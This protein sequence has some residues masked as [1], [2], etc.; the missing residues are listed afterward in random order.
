M[1]TNPI[2]ASGS[3]NVPAEKCCERKVEAPVATEQD[4]TEMEFPNEK[5]ETY[6]EKASASVNEY[7]VT[8]TP[9]VP[10]K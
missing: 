6:A 10:K 3:R 5:G 8:W 2:G 7:E 4:V 1:K 9:V